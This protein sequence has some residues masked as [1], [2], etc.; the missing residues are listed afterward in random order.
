VPHYEI[1]VPLVL[2]AG[3]AGAALTQVRLIQARAAAET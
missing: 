1:L 3:T 2:V